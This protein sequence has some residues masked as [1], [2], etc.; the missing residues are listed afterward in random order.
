MSSNLQSTEKLYP[1]SQVWSPQNNYWTPES[2]N[3]IP[4]MEIHIQFPN[5]RFE[6]FYIETQQYQVNYENEY[7]QPIIGGTLH[8]NALTWPDGHIYF[9]IH[10]IDSSG[11]D[12]LIDQIEIRN[13]PW[14]YNYLQTYNVSKYKSFYF[15]ISA[16]NIH[17]YAGLYCA[18]LIVPYGFN[19]Y[20]TIHP[21]NQYVNMQAYVYDVSSGA[22]IS[23][24]TVTLSDSAG[25]ISGEQETTSSN[26]Y[27]IFNDVPFSDLDTYYFSATAKNYKSYTVQYSGQ[28]LANNNYIVKIPLAYETPTALS[29]F[30]NFAKYAGI[31]LIVVGV[32]AGGIAAYKALSKKEK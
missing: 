3:G 5:Y 16:I 30:E 15:R 23:N 17:V 8:C 19:I 27:A 7:I 6:T 1:V 32:S 20:G 31:A 29:S 11:N 13:L 2:Y 14:P 10:G 9:E 4:D 22:P 18:G 21:P 26:G 12:S 24:A 28:D 25:F